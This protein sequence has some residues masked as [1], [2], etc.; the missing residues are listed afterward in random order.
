MGIS[1]T[2]EQLLAEPLYAP[3][4][5]VY[6]I[7]PVKGKLFIYAPKKHMKSLVA[8]NMMYDLA[9]GLP[10]LGQ[11]NWKGKRNFTSLIIE[12]ELGERVNYHRFKKIDEY[13]GGTC[14]SNIRV[15]SKNRNVKLDS[16]E[17]IVMLRKELEETTPDILVLDPLRKFHRQ[18][19]ND[20]TS[21][22]KVVDQM[23]RLIEDF[24]VSLVILHHAGHSFEGQPVKM[25]GTSV[26]GDEA[27]G[28]LKLQ[29]PEANNK[30]HIRVITEELRHAEPERPFDLWL[31]PDTYTFSTERPK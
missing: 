27:D 17:G 11:E 20:S 5:I 9:E 4:F 8:F 23:D 29:R 28:I 3:P 19:E 6:P 26:W 10:V 30:K 24:N 14:Q 16:R 15:V 22:T 2:L 1:K 13:R 31:N 18:D 21:V 12:Q 7:L 25:R